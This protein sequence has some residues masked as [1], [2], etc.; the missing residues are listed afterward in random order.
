MKIALIVIVS[1]LIGSF[2]PAYFLGRIIGKKDIREYGSGNAGTTNALRVFGKNVAAA[3]LLLDIL[4]GIIAILIGRY[5]LGVNGG[6]LG[7]LFAVL[8]HN[9]PIFLNFKG[10]KG[11]AT[12]LGV[13][14]TLNWK[15][16]LICLVIGLVFIIFSKYVSLGSIMASVA[17][18]FVSYILAGSVEDYLFLTTLILALLSIYRHRSNI[19]RL[20]ANKESKIDF[21]SGN[22]DR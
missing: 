20:L 13:L 9:W 5:I 17:A 6:Y 22:K 14:F 12:S 8:G 4:K 2:S 18:P 1:Y 16:G 11:I 10:G 19:G 3:T 7:G 21:K 15:L